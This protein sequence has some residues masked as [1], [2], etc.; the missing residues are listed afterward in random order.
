MKRIKN[1][2]EL[3][4]IKLAEI[5][6]GLEGFYVTITKAFIIFL[7]SLLLNSF[8]ETLLFLIFFNIMRFTSFGLH[9]SKSW[10]CWVASIIVFVGLPVILQYFVLPNTIKFILCIV[11]I[12]LIFLY[13]PADTKKHPLVNPKKRK[14]LKCISTFNAILL[15]VL[16]FKFVDLSNFIICAIYIE[17]VLILPI[18][19][20]IFH[21]EYRN[22]EKV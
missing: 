1:N 22:Y 14:V 7:C 10:I 11:A 20:H 16:S 9:A 19:Y 5:R 4:E 17:I 18:T 21:F 12:I 6:Y 13:A 2:Y 3:D 15:S 8:K